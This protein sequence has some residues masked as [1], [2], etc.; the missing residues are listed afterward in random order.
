MNE[1]ST[2]LY[3]SL[4]GSSTDYSFKNKVASATPIDQNIASAK[5]RI[6]RDIDMALAVGGELCVMLLAELTSFYSK[7]TYYM[8]VR[9]AIEMRRYRPSV[10]EYLKLSVDER[11]ERLHEVLKES[12]RKDKNRDLKVTALKYFLSTYTSR[13]TEF[14]KLL[15]KEEFLIVA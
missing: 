6:K 8:A 13:I 7:E 15:T 1:R 3:K 12:I 11:A 2:D 5:K 9:G 4:V 14:R 10:L